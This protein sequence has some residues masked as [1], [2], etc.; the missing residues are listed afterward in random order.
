MKMY[1]LDG[2]DLILPGQRLYIVMMEEMIP[3]RSIG[4]SQD[5]QDV[6]CI[7]VVVILFTPVNKI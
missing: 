1:A 6:E 4:G 2:I 3:N 7:F 5:R